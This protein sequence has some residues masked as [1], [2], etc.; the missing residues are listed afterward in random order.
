MISTVFPDVTFDLIL[1]VGDFAVESF[2]KI[3]TAPSIWQKAWFFGNKLVENMS[4]YLISIRR[5][6]Y[7]CYFQTAMRRRREKRKIYFFR[8][9]IDETEF[10]S[11]DLE[12]LERVWAEA[13]L[14][15]FYGQFRILIPVY[16]LSKKSEIPVY[17]NRACTEPT[18][19][20]RRH[21]KSQASKLIKIT[22]NG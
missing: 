1:T 8:C 17:I 15:N 3:G 14:N 16:R 18:N 19:R 6:F 7:D 12:C 10:F 11:L 13:K 20:F 22:R 21:P 2:K 4:G 9:A 5:D